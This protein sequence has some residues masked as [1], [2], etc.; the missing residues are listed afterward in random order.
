MLG[1]CVATN[2]EKRNI[3]IDACCLIDL[4]QQDAGYTTQQNRNQHLEFCRLFLDAG[5]N[6]DHVIYGSTFLIAE[7][8]SI[9][10]DLVTR[11]RICTD[12][13]K[14]LFTKMLMS[15]N[16]IMPVQPTPRI[17]ELSR[18]L[19]WEDKLI[20]GKI[21]PADRV[22]LATAIEMKCEGFITADENLI[23]IKPAIQKKYK[24]QICTADVLKSWLPDSSKQLKLTGA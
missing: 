9:R 23:K 15:G 4:A 8:V 1:K 12:A 10:E 7:C 6:D 21:G 19:A 16:P 3:Y 13:V 5:R 22:H 2:K 20:G 14:V 11:K 17:L 24:I 18:K